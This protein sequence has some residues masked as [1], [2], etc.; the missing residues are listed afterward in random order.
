MWEFL[1]RFVT[2]ACPRIRDFRGLGT[3]AF[4]GRGNFTLGIKEQMIFPEINYDMV[5]QI[6]G[7]DITFVT[8]AE[9]DEVALA[10]LH[11]LGVPFRGDEKPVT[12]KVAQPAEAA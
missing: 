3:K 11:Q 8:T 1:D 6:H 4:D 12:P 7:F 2:V 9:K 5:E 10:L